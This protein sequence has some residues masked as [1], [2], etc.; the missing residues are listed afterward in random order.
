M[1]PMQPLRS[2][3]LCTL[4]A[5][6][7]N[8][9]IG[10]TPKGARVFAIVTGGTIAG[11]RLNG[12]LLPGGGDFALITSDGRLQVDVRVAAELDDGTL[13]YGTYYGKL[14]I[15]ADMIA[16]AMDP[17]KRDTLDHGR[18][19]FRTAPM[20]ETAAPAYEWLNGILCVGVGRLTPTGVAYD[21]HEI[22]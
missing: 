19:Y 4:N 14:N 10:Q 18:I 12:R 11:D 1:A 13:I 8:T 20:F 6:I 21:V 7:D 17:S 3:F 15:P 2:K 16:D 9:A 5:E 22:L